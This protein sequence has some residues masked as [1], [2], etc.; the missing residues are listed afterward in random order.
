MIFYIDYK[1]KMMEHFTFYKWEINQSNYYNEARTNYKASKWN[2][3]A[4]KQINPPSKY[5]DLPVTRLRYIREIYPPN[6]FS[7]SPNSNTSTDSSDSLDT[8]PLY[9]ICV[10]CKEPRAIYLVACSKSRSSSGKWY[11]EQC[12]KNDELNKRKRIIRPKTPPK[13][14]N[15]EVCSC[16]C[17]CPRRTPSPPETDKSI[18]LQ[19][20][21]DKPLEFLN[22][23]NSV[24]SP[25][26]P[27]IS[28]NQEN[29]DV[30]KKENGKY[31]SKLRNILD[32]I[33]KNMTDYSL[34]LIGDPN[35]GYC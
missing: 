5:E 15:S 28:N 34:S 25:I 29:I 18:N 32:S 21:K 23:P 13:I 9:P 4:N 16:P 30:I 35:F 26:T 22:S 33:T 20:K 1:Y 2:K 17:P 7:D 31:V 10:E 6:N 8:M 24:D 27:I 3:S 11:C 14:S 19:D 12:L